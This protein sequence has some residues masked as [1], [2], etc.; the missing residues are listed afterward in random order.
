MYSALDFQLMLENFS[1][2]ELLSLSQSMLLIAGKYL[3]SQG[4]TEKAKSQFKI[5]N[6]IMNAF[7]DDFLESKWFKATLF[8]TTSEQRFE[9]E[10][11]LNE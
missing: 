1:Q 8:E 2:N 10:K 3:K 5:A 7:S 11:L 9:V 6:K 4:E